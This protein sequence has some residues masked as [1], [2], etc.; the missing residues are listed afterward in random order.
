[1]LFTDTAQPLSSAG[2]SRASM[3]CVN[4]VEQPKASTP[5]AAVALLSRITACTAKGGLS[6]ELV[7]LFDRLALVAFCTLH[8][9]KSL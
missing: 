9:A 8:S 3:A 4:V 6:M 5:S 2:M 7:Y 1:M